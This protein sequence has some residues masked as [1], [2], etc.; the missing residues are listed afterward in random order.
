MPINSIV[1]YTCITGDYDDLKEVQKATDVDYVCFTD[2]PIE[3]ETWDVRPIE[4]YL[5]EEYQN[6][7]NNR[8]A[9]WFKLHPHIIFPEYEYSVWVDGSVTVKKDLTELVL[10][11]DWGVFPHAS[12]HCIMEEA[13][14]CADLGKDDPDLMAKQI[15]HYIIG[16]NYPR[17]NGLAENTIIVRKH[18]NVREV[19]ES[20]WQE[21]LKWS[22]RDQLSFNYVCW[23]QGFEYTELPGTVYSNDWFKVHG[24]KS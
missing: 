7:D 18:E 3:S 11:V 4:E 6:L 20:W 23:K 10:D 19:S 5:P 24:H 2:K 1:V 8:R 22:K 9:K 21:I 13:F 17:G 12:R 15:S 16:N 14:A